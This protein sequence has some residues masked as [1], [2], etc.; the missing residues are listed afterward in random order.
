MDTTIRD[1]ETEIT[2]KA[3]SPKRLYP[4]FG[5]FPVL[6]REGFKPLIAAIATSLCFYA[7]G[8]VQAAWR[9]CLISRRPTD[10]AADDANPDT[11]TSSTSYIRL[12]QNQ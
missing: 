9:A 2:H 12:A 1:F 5:H 10:M 7:N 11:G 4:R 6:Q 8:A 3:Q